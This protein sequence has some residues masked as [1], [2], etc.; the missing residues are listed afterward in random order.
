MYTVQFIGMMCFFKQPNA[1]LVLLPDGTQMTPKHSARI[2]V[3]P[4]QVNGSSGNWPTAAAKQG[5]FVLDQDFDIVIEGVDQNGTL[6]VSKHDPVRLPAGFA[7]DLTTARTIGRI[8]IR[9]G[10]L[11]TFRYPG[12]NDTIE[13][14]TISQLDVPHTGVIRITATVRSNPSVVRTIE[15]KAGTEIA[16]VNDSADTS[17]DHFHIYSQLGQGPTALGNT[18][19]SEVGK[20]HRSQSQHKVFFKPDPIVDG[21]RCPNTGCC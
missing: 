14:S 3:D 15:L 1:R 20:F 9:Q 19:D 17:H 6:D 18:P 10:I 16:I 21:V 12:T 4:K 2:A 5:D 13:A 7:I 8:A 11:Q